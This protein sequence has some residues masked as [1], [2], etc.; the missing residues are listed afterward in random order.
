[1]LE[2]LDIRFSF[3][4]RKTHKN[5]E[6]KNPIIFRVTFRS[7]RRDIFTGLYCFKRNWNLKEGKVI[8]RDKDAEAI[9]QNLEIILRKAHNIFDGL[10]FSN[11]EFTID[12]LISKLKGETEE[13]PELLM[14]YLENGN[15]AI[16]QRVG[17]EIAKATYYKYRRSLQYMQEFL[18]KH[19]KVKNFTVKR[20]D[21]KFLEAY[22]HFLR[23]EKNISHNVSRRYIN[24]V[25]TIIYPSVRNGIIK[26]DPFRELKIKPKPVVREFLSQEEV[27]VLVALKINDPDLER[28]K[29]IF[30]FA[31]FTGLAY[32]D[33]K[34]L[35]SEHLA[36]ESDGTWFIR[37]PRQKTGEQSIIPLLPIAIRILQRYSMTGNLKDFKWYVSSNQKMNEGLKH[38]GR[39]S[40]ISKTLHMHLARHTFAT[41]ITLANGIPIESVSKMLGHSDIRQ[42]QHYAKVVGL[43]IKNDMKKIERLYE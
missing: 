14:E 29:D 8:N 32:I 37:K 17:I 9:N 22:F 21:V 43:K 16:F 15:K 7:S 5:K 28:K 30:L 33:I 36:Q 2:L 26:I 23:V 25:K 18:L 38:I 40:G 31:C 4:C 10:R 27:D 35:N 3:L 20:I 34:G 19:Y 41:T 39:R 1:M 6:G 42:T 24:F 13:E 12:E 11:E